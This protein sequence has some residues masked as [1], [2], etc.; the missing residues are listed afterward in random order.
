V[1]SHPVAHRCLRRLIFIENPEAENRRAERHKQSEA[2][3]AGGKAAAAASSSASFAPITV[4]ATPARFAALM[5]EH[6][7][8]RYAQFAH[9]C[10]AFVIVAMM[11]NGA[12]QD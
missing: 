2:P 3:K 7:S 9:T 4:P 1:L 5:H 10:G 6:L 8:G 12:F 11:E